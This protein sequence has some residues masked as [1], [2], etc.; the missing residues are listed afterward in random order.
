MLVDDCDEVLENN[1]TVA[2]VACPKVCFMD[3]GLYMCSVCYANFRFK[4]NAQA[5]IKEKHLR[6]RKHQC[7]H[8]VYK[9]NRLWNLKMH[10]ASCPRKPHWLCAVPCG[11]KDVCFICSCFIRCSVAHLLTESTGS[12]AQCVVQSSS[13]VEHSIDT[14]VR[15][16][17][18]LSTHA[19]LVLLHFGGRITS[20][21]TWKTSMDLLCQAK[22]I[23]AGIMSDC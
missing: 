16:T 18:H 12:H 23:G 10:L 19:R 22:T 4:G 20:S 8:C 21:G 15:H 9:S 11:L 17:L 2:A 5:H 7:P 14:S 6:S 13:I 1:S 3:S